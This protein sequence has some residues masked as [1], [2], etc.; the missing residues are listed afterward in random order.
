MDDDTMDKMDSTATAAERLHTLYVDEL[1]RS[2]RPPVDPKVNR[3]Q[4]E[5]MIERALTEQPGLCEAPDA[6]T[7]IWSLP[8][9]SP[10]GRPARRAVCRQEPHCLRSYPAAGLKG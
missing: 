4:T 10:R 2:L 6:A 7:W 3:K 5:A 8:A 1:R 9:P